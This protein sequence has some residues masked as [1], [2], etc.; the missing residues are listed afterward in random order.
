M[1]DHR[2]DIENYFPE[3]H[4]AHCSVLNNQALLHKLNGKY[5]LALGMFRDVYET[6]CV[7]H[8][9]HHTSTLNTLINVATT[10]RDLKEN[11]KAAELYEKAIIGREATEGD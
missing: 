11:E 7:V 3:E 10:Y 4:P 9:E 6:Y 2:V 5:D 8:G 1:D